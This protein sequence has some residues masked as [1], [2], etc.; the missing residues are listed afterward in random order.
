MPATPRDSHDGAGLAGDGRL[1]ALGEDSLAAVPTWHQA[2]I[3]IAEPMGDRY[4]FLRLDAPTIAAAARPGQFV[5]LG[6]TRDP[7]GDPVLPR[8]M[9]IFERD[10][11]AGTIDIVYGVVG[12]GTKQL[13]SFRSDET[14]LTIGPL[15]RG[16]DLQPAT[17]ATLIVGRGIGTCSLTMLTQEAAAAGVGCTAV[18]SGRRAEAVVGVEQYAAA[19]VT[20]LHQVTDAEGTSDPAKLEAMLVREL[21]PAPPQQIFTCGSDRLARLCIALGKRWQADVQVSLEAHMACGIGY[22]HGCSSGQRTATAEAPLVCKDGPVFRWA[23][24]EETVVS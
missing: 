17:T 15:G 6:A 24:S 10:V 7:D 18:A 2:P 12:H 19:G 3:V 23:A 4:H 5:M 9:A 14:M 21:D 1:E 11:D 8:P 20:S 13:T 22:C 16:F